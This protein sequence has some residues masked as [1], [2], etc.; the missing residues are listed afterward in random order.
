[1]CGVQKRTE[2]RHQEDQPAA[3]HT[4]R[5]GLG[6]PGKEGYRLYRGEIEKTALDPPIDRGGR[7][8]VPGIWFQRLQ[9]LQ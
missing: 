4:C 8:G 1:M 3:S 2:R 9:E 5:K 7:T 6:I